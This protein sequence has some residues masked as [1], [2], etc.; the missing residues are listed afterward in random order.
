MSNTS[1]IAIKSLDR[2]SGSSHNFVYRLPTNIKNVKR[3]SLLNAEIPLTSYTVRSG[4]NNTF[5]F[6]RSSTTYTATVTEGY[7]S[8][9]TLLTALATAIAAAD[10]STTASLAISTTTLKITLAASNSIT[11]SDTILGEQLGFTAGQSGTTITATNAYVIGDSHLFIQL[12]NLTTNMISAVPAHFRIQLTADVGYLQF[13]DGSQNPQQVDTD[14]S[15]LNHLEVA[16]VD[17]LGYSLS[18]NGAEWSL[19]LEVKYDE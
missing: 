3:L 2:S 12:K 11:I 15:T 10:T 9:S 13:Y 4:V 8:A 19:L 18:L 5:T 17:S 16:L 7:Y 6:I 14:G 1:Y